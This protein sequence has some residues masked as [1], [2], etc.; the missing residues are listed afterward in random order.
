MGVQVFRDE[1]REGRIGIAKI[2]AVNK[3]GLKNQW[4]VRTWGRDINLTTA[5]LKAEP[6]RLRLA[7]LLKKHK[8]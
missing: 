1:R 4:V 3:N 5:N 2:G 7:I 6:N 8:P